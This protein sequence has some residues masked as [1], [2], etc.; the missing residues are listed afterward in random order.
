MISPDDLK[1]ACTKLDTSSKHFY[2]K[3][4]GSGVKTMQSRSFSE[5]KYYERMGDTLKKHIRG[6]TP[7]RLAEEMNINEVLIKEHLHQAETRG[8]ICRDESH[9]GVRYFFNHFKTVKL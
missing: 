6:L 9:E 7:M 3:T 5:D 2:L 8:F 1:V 4:Y